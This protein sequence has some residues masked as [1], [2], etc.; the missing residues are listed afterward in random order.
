MSQPPPS[1]AG[2]LQSLRSI[3]ASF[4]A[5]L[6][7]RIE[8]AVLELREEG[9]RRKEMLVLAAV[10]GVF[11]T[12]AALLLAAF[13]VILFWDTHRVVAAGGVTALY[14]AIGVFALA[15]MRGRARD[16][17]PPFEATLAELARDVQALKGRDE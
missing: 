5:L 15:R 3:G 7:T 17:P 2:P 13:V 10:A 4:V 12:L 9:Q 14:L 11:L 1:E 16:N 6:H 8:L